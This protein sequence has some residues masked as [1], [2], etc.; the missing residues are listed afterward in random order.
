MKV[1]VS[2]W[3]IIIILVALLLLLVS[4]AK[5]LKYNWNVLYNIENQ[6]YDLELLKE[7]LSKG[8]K[9]FF[10]ETDIPFHRW[11]NDWYEKKCSY[12]F[13]GSLFNPDSTDV[14]ALLGF[15]SYGN[16][17]VISSQNFG[18]VFRNQLN[19][20]IEFAL[21]EMK[22]SNDTDYLITVYDDL[23]TI[24]YTLN[25]FGPDKVK[26]PYHFQHIKQNDSFNGYLAKGWDEKRNLNFF[27]IAIGEGSLT[28]HLTP[29]LLTNYHLKNLE[30]ERYA[31][32]IFKTEYNAK[33]FWES[34]RSVL[35]TSETV[36]AGKQ[37]PFVYIFSQASLK[38]AFTLILSGLFIFL[39]FSSKRKQAAIPI[40]HQPENTTLRF[41]DNMKEL[42]KLQPNY[43]D[44]ARF[45]YL[46]FMQWLQR[47]YMIDRSELKQA[48][49][50]DRMQSLCKWDKD[51]IS[52]FVSNLRRLEA[53]EPFSDVMLYHVSLQ[54]ERFYAGKN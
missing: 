17:A 37:N 14:M 54:F 2:I 30:A 40:F 49:F 35:P 4:N 29:L 8:N 27:T 11:M 41:L 13:C 46:Y 36:T 33:V 5:T 47:N 32:Q 39:L 21:P 7:T 24:K 50:Q 18:D 3:V 12:I 10:S 1:R 52:R 31:E 26:Y 19:D 28:L 53:H 42:H 16:N 23:D 6:P 25:Y 22:Y 9:G 34:R 44:I 43:T 48:G 51:E 20:Y 38:W 15:I 45:R